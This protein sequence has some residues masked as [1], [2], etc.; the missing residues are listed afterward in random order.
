[1]LFE[2]GILVQ[3][4]IYIYP[5]TSCEKYHISGKHDMLQNIKKYNVFQEYIVTILQKYC[6]LVLRSCNCI[7][8]NSLSH[9]IRKSIWLAYIIS[10]V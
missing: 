8:G 2:N 10:G 4:C 5:V 3:L 7:T 1:M 6:M 9:I